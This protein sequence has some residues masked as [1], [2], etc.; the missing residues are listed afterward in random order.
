M[1]HMVR[2][3]H[4]KYSLIHAHAISFLSLADSN[5]FLSKLFRACPLAPLF[6]LLI[7]LWLPKDRYDSSHL[8]SANEKRK[9]GKATTLIACSLVGVFRCD[10]LKDL[11]MN[12]SEDVAESNRVLLDT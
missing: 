1:P 5:V 4:H 8:V 11:L 3:I 6:L 9:A 12:R 10:K 7:L 2:Q